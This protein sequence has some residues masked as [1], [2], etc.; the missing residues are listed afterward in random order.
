LLVGVV[1]LATVDDPVTRRLEKQLEEIRRASENGIDGRR[2]NE[3]SRDL[4]QF[5]LQL[6]PGAVPKVAAV[7]AREPGLHGRALLIRGLGSID[8]AEAVSALD[9]HIRHRL[10]RAHAGP[11]DVE[12][13]VGFATLEQMTHPASLEALLVFIE[14][15]PTVARGFAL[16]GSRGKRGV[17][18]HAEAYLEWLADSDVAIRSAAALGLHDLRRE[19]PPEARKKIAAA[20][21]ELL[22]V[23]TELVPI[24]DAITTLGSMRW[25]GTE[26]ALGAQLSSEQ[27]RTR[28]RAVEALTEVGSP[29]SADL[30]EAHVEVETS[31]RVRVKALRGMSAI[32][33]ED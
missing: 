26:A 25:E 30:L 14:E 8:G 1:L 15:G 32:R 23:E 28:E 7:L 31:G 24:H 20:L 19:A 10:Q 18:D 21:V 27:M 29:E 11:G 2:H 12:L 16:A 4:T 6:R 13:R 22:A 5:M 3:A 17:F 9:A 33:G